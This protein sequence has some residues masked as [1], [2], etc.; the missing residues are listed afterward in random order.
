MRPDTTTKI[1]GRIASVTECRI[2]LA[3]GSTPQGAYRLLAEH[4]EPGVIASLQ[5][6]PT[7]LHRMITGF[8]WPAR[9]RGPVS[10]NSR[11]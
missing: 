9:I 5:E 3:G 8:G 4:G 2:A 1:G 11:V 6:N 10:V 7:Q